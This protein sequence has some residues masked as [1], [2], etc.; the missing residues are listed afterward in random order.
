MRAMPVPPTKPCC[1]P[2]RGA[3][4]QRALALL[5]CCVI[6]GCVAKG[7]KSVSSPG[8]D[9]QRSA[10]PRPGVAAPRNEGLGAVRLVEEGRA[11]R[12]AGA[13]ER[14]RHAF[15]AA[16]RSAPEFGIAHLEWAIT[17]QFLGLPAEEIR[18][19]FA[20][21]MAL[22]PENPRAWF[23][24]GVF[25]EAHGDDDAARRAYQEAVTLRA[26]YTD[27]ALRLAALLFRAGAIDEAYA[28]YQHVIGQLP[29]SVPALLGFAEVAER[30]GALVE[31]EAALR[32]IIDLY[33]G[34][35]PHRQRLVAFFVR[36][37]QDEKAERA[38]SEVEARSPKDERRLR[39]LKPSRR[40]K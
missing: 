27:A 18:P 39:R 35:L 37:A 25:E 29:K 8:P 5:A 9:M 22:M 38:R 7:A 13:Y 33:P 21:V 30:K 23:E 11:H 32:S 4:S 14:A 34:V 1:A 3:L 28:Q 36:T 12:V 17:A 26:E 10:L 40:R 2:A 24:L 6:G 16:I 15:E 31:A 20:R 19:R